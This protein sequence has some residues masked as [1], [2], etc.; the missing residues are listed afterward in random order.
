MIANR[1]GGDDLKPAEWA[2]STRAMRHADLPHDA[3]DRHSSE[4]PTGC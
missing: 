3:W 4:R 1:D 2:A